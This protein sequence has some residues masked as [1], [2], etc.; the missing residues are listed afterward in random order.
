MPPSLYSPVTYSKP[1]SINLQAS[2]AFVAA[3]AAAHVGSGNA[4]AETGGIDGEGEEDEEGSQE[5]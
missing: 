1:T 2:S 4:E 3:R 5:A